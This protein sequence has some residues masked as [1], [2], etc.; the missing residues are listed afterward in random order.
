M[1]PSRAAE[2]WK[3]AFHSHRCFGSC[4]GSIVQKSTLAARIVHSPHDSPSQVH[5]PV[6]VPA[7]CVLDAPSGF[8]S[9]TSYIPSIDWGKTIRPEKARCSRPLKTCPLEKRKA[10]GGG[11]RMG[12]LT[13]TEQPR[14]PVH[15]SFNTFPRSSSSSHSTLLCR[16]SLSNLSPS[17]SSSH[18]PD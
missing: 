4:Q 13:R 12:Y 16:P 2:I 1:R 7:R 11:Y 17:S 8:P 14:R 15:L 10:M 18:R 5:S 3:D 6:R 9:R